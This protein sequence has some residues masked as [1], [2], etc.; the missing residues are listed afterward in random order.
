[1]DTINIKNVVI[2]NYNKTFCSFGGV[3][4]GGE[5]VDL[6]Q[7]IR[8]LRAPLLQMAWHSLGQ[9]TRWKTV[10]AKPFNIQTVALRPPF[11]FLAKSSLQLRRCSAVDRLE[12]VHTEQR[13]GGPGAD[14]GPQQLTYGPW[15]PKQDQYQSREVISCM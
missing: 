15:E 4:G 7:F 14:K 13:E 11:F 10:I 8:L 3:G 1:M 5:M 6:R 9:Q 12:P 2:K